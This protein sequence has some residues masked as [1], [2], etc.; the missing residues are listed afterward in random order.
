MASASDLSYNIVK[1]TNDSILAN[2]A[3]LHRTED[4]LRRQ[5]NAAGLSDADKSKIIAEINTLT[6]LQASLY[7]SMNNNFS[8]YESGVVNER[9]A[10]LDRVSATT[11]MD[12][13]SQQ[14]DADSNKSR[15]RLRQIEINTYYS[16]QYSA[17]TGIMQMFVVFSLVFF[18]IYLLRYFNI[19]SVNI[20]IILC[21]IVAVFASFY[22]GRRIIDIMNRDNM[23]FD[24]YNWKP[25]AP[26]VA[27]T[28]PSVSGSIN[29]WI[30]NPLSCIGQQCCS[31]GMTFD[32]AKGVCV[33][34]SSGS[35][36]PAPTTAI[37]S[38]TG[39]P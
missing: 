23:N 19:V 37:S 4:T 22:I 26:S 5:L 13:R 35:L 11:F 18:M 34:A 30:S 12:Q 3:K 21:I 36:C 17:Q 16:K 15:E 29:P 24:E 28:T 10:L 20:S 9:S 25:P 39:S 32:D 1:L 31:T 7:T 27:Q 38:G 2:I 8:L 6:A 14:M 33:V